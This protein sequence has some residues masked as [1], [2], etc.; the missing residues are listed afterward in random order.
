MT[1]PRT[2]LDS[3]TGY[4]AAILGFDGP[5]DPSDGGFRLTRDPDGWFVLNGPDGEILMSPEMASVVA[6]EVLSA[7]DVMPRKAVAA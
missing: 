2:L 6:R 4:D 5:V 1:A 7:L 3:A